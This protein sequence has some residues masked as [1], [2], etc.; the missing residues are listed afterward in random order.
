MRIIKNDVNDYII[1]NKFTKPILPNDYQE[2]EYIE[3]IN[4]AIIIT[5]VIIDKATTIEWKS[6][7]IQFTSYGS[8]INSSVSE[9]NGLHEV[10]YSSSGSKVYMW[11]GTSGFNSFSSKSLNLNIIYNF[12]AIWDK[13]LSNKKSLLYIDD[14]VYG[15]VNCDYTGKDIKIMNATSRYYY[16]KIYQD[17]ILIRN[18]V[19]CYRKLDNEIGMYDTVNGVFYTNQGTGTFIKGP[20]VNNYTANRYRLGDLTKFQ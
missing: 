6:M 10:G 7:P 16:Y 1:K 11:T 8:F 5:E 3:S 12:K 13:S 4:N 19:P 15:S 17:N 9:K 18:F 20:D 2:V 14:A